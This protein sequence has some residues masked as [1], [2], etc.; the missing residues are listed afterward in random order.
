MKNG[1]LEIV[2]LE[3]CFTQ[4][5]S[6]ATLHDAMWV[7]EQDYENWYGDKN[8]A[9]KM[10][11]DQLKKKYFNNLQALNFTNNTNLS[12]TFNLANFKK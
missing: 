3:G 5:N 10:S 6:L 11:G 1:S 8:K 2:D 9:Q 7:S 4:R 12:T